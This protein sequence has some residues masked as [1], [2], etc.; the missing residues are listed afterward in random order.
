[1]PNLIVTLGYGRASG[2]STKA[3]LIVTLGYGNYIEL[4]QLLTRYSL[5]NIKRSLDK[6]IYDNLGVIENMRVDYEGV[7]FNTMT[8]NEWAVPRIVSMRRNFHRQGSDTEYGQTNNIVYGININVKKSGATTTD[9]HYVLRDDIVSYFRVGQDIP[10]RDYSA[11]GSTLVCYMRVRDLVEDNSL[12]DNNEL[13]KY[14]VGVKLD[15]TEMVPE[16]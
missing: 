1:M 12:K 13:L 14:K 7:P 8:V 10:L 16:A 3:N 15:F 4:L 11:S 6:Y 5:V 2:L 9:R